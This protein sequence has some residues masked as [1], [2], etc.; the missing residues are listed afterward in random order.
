MKHERK[1]SEKSVLLCW[2][3]FNVL[4]VATSS[5]VGGAASSSM[6]VPSVAAGGDWRETARGPPGRRAPAFLCFAHA[7][8]EQTTMLLETS[9]HAPALLVLS[10]A[11]C[12]PYFCIYVL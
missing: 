7:Q 11:I 1:R 5:R 6:R 8:Y 2:H 10:T 9:A 3:F 12:E 4:I